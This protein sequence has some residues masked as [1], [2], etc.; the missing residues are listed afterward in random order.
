MSEVHCLYCNRPASLTI[1]GMVNTVL[2]HYPTCET[3]IELVAYRVQADRRDVGPVRERPAPEVD[4]LPL[5]SERV[6]DAV[7]DL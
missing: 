2:A 6:I 7:P 3:H 1:T 5:W 4:S